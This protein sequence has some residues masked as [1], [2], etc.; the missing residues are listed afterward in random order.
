MSGA[1]ASQSASHSG[2]AAADRPVLAMAQEGG[3]GG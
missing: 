2:R 1:D 3:D